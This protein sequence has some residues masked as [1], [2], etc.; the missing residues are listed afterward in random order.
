MVLDQ[1]KVSK[2]LLDKVFNMLELARDTGKLRR[3]TNE[4]TKS[5][6]SGVAKFVIIAEN[7]NP[8]EIVMHL[9]IICEE[10][11]IP[12]VVG[13]TKEELGTLSGIKVSSASVAIEKLGEA[14]KIYDEIV[15]QLKELRK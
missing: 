14:K 3:G 1:Y 12:F 4:V 11:G 8:P 9:P 5:V 15:K 7:V 6:E 2:E 10:K 13:G